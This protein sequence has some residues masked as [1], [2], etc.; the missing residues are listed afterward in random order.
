MEILIRQQLSDAEKEQNVDALK[1]TYQLIKS[2]HDGKSALDSLESFSFDLYV[3]CAE[4]A[5]QMGLPEISH[6]C[7]QMYFKGKAPVNQFLGRAY[8]CQSQLY[9]PVST[10][11]LEQFE[12]FNINLLKTIDFA[13]SDIRYYFLIYNASVIYWKNIRPFLKPGSRNFLIPSLSQIVSAL[14]HPDE[15]D[16]DWTAELMIELLECFLDASRVEEATTFSSTAATF[17]EENAPSRYKD[18]FSIMVRNKLVDAS[19]IE[20]K[21]ESC[22]SLNIIYKIQTIKGQLDKNQILEDAP[23]DLNNI[24]ELLKGSKKQVNRNERIS[25]LLELARLSLRLNCINIA[26][27]CLK[28][29][30]IYKIHDPGREIELD[31]LECDCEVQALGP[32]IETYAKSVVEAQLEVI[33]KLDLILNRAI[34]LR[35]PNIIQAVCTTQWNICL[36]LL[37]HNLQHH[38]RKPLLA[39]AEVLEKIDSMLILLRCQ[40]HMEI[41]RIEEKSDRVETAMEHLE[42]AINLDN[43]GQYHEYLKMAF[44]RLSL[45]TMLYKSLERLE[46]QASLMIEQ[47]KKGTANDSVRKKRSLLVNAGLA[48]APEAFQVVLDS[49]NEAKVPPSKHKDQISYLCA[50]AE[51]HAKNVEKADGHLKRLGHEN[52]KERIRLWSEIAKTA[53]KQSVW[54]VCRAACRFCLLYDDNQVIKVSKRKKLM[55]KKGSTSTTPDEP[56]VNVLR[57][58]PVPTKIF[59]LERDLLRTLAEVRCINAEATI[60][61]LRTEGVQLNDYPVLPIEPNTH[62]SGYSQHSTRSGRESDWNVY[63]NWI[64]RLSQYAMENFLRAVRIGEELNEAWI[65]HNTVVYVLNHNKHLIISK[66][67]R[68][69]VE[70]FQILFNAVKNVGNFGNSTVLVTLCNALARGLILPWIPRMV[71]KTDE[72]KLNEEGPTKRKKTALK[73]YDKSLTALITPVDPSGIHDIKAAVEVCEFAMR[74]PNGSAPDEPVPIALRQQVI[75]TWVKAKQLLQQQIGRLHGSEEESN[76]DGTSPMTKVFMGL[77][78]YSC[79]GLS[80]MDFLLP[81]LSQLVKMALECSWSDSLVQLQTLTRLMHFAHNLHDHELVITCSQKILELGKMPFNIDPKKKGINDYSARQEML[82]IASCTQGKSIMEN[83]AGKKHLRVTASNSFVESARYAGEAGNLNL[84]MVAARNFWNACLPFIGSSA[85]R[86]HLKAPTE[87]ILK[88]IIKA[89]EAKN[90]QEAS[91]MLHLHQW[92]T[93]DFQSISPSDGHFFPG[94]EEDLTLRTFLY[95]LL[96]QAYA[97][98]NE[99]E[100][101][102]KVLDEAVQILPRTKHRLPIFKHMVMVKAR[103]GR[104]YIMEIQKFRDETEVY[105]SDMWHRLASVSFDIVG[106]LSCYQNAIEV[107]Q[108]KESELKK[109]DNILGFAEWLYCKQ[110]PL[111]EAI[112]HLEWAIN[113]LLYLKPLQKSPDEE[114]VRNQ[115]SIG[116]LRSIKQLEAL[117]RAYTI[118]AVISGHRSTFYEQYCLMAYAFVIRMW[119]MSFTTAG[120]FLKAQTKVSPAQSAT[121]KSKDKKDGKKP[122]AT[123]VSPTS[124]PKKDKEKSPKDG[125]KGGSASKEKVKKKG[126]IDVLPG[127]VEEWASYECPDEMREAFKQDSSGCTVNRETILAPTRTLYYLDLLLKELQSM[128]CTHMTLPLLH[129]AEIIAHDVV[130]SKSLSNLYHLRLAKICLDLKMYQAASF[131]EKAVG[132]IFINEKEQGRFRQEIAFKNENAIQDNQMENKNFDWTELDIEQRKKL[133]TA[134]DKILELNAVTEKELN[135]LSLPYLWIEKAEVLIQLCLYQPARLLLSE[136]HQATQEMNNPCGVSR[137]L[138]LLAVLANLEKNHGQSKALLEKARLIGGNEQFWH[139]STFALTDAILGDDQEINEKM[140]QACHFLQK[141]INV[142][143]PLLKERPNR[144]SELGFIIACFEARK[145]YIQIDLVKYLI[146]TSIFSD[147]LATILLESYDKLIHIEKIFLSYGYKDRSADAL[148]ACANIH[149]ILGKH[150]EEAADK[151][152]HYIE[153]YR[154]AQCGVS[155]MEELFQHINNIL[156]VNET[157][158][159]NTPLMR[160]L[161]NMKVNFVEI[162]LD[163]FVLINIEKKNQEAR[164]DQIEQIIE[165]FVRFTPDSASGEQAWITLG[166]TV[167]HNAHAQLTSLPSLCGGCPDIRAKYL[168]LTGRSLH[169]LA[170]HIEPFN[171]DIQWCDNAIEVPKINSEKSPPPEAETIDEQNEV[172]S[173]M[174]QLTRKQLGDYRKKAN[175]LRKRQTWTHEYIFQSTEVLLQCINVAINNNLIDTLAAASLEMVECFGQFDPVSASQF[176]ALYQSCTASLIMKEILLGATLNSSSSQMAAMLH[177]Q[178]HLQQKGETSGLLKTIEHR[179]AAISKAWGSL[180]IS[181]HHFNIMNELPANFHIVILQ[182]SGDRSLLYGAV[183]EKVKSTNPKEQK[184]HQ[185]EKGGKEKGGQQKGKFAQPTFQAKIVRTSVN[186]ETFLNILEKVDVYKEEMMDSLL[187]EIEEDEFQRK[188]VSSAKLDTNIEDEDEPDLDFMFQAI[189]SDMEEYLKPVLSQLKLSELRRQSPSASPADSGKTRKGS[190]GKTKTDDSGK[191]KTKTSGQG[192][193]DIGECVILLADKD[194]LE[195]PLEALTIFQDD[196]ISSLSRDFSLQMVYNRIRK[197]EGDGE[198]KKS[199]RPKSEQRRGT[200]VPSLNRTLPP[201]CI[202]IDVHNVKY[203]V[204]PYND[205][206]EDELENPANSFRRILEK[207][208]PFTICWEGIMGDIHFPSYTEWEYILNNCSMLF[209]SAMARFLSHVALDKLVAM[210]IP[211]CQLIILSGRVHS[212]PSLIRLRN[213]DEGK[214]SLR[215]SLEKTT[216][217]AIILSL[218]GVRSV[219]L[220]QWFTTLEENTMRLESLCENFIKVGKTTGQAV[221]IL[222]RKKTVWDKPPE[223]SPDSLGVEKEDQSK[224]PSQPNQTPIHPSVIDA[225]LYG[226]PNTMFT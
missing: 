31:C 128:L 220:N 183:L 187:R 8:L 95:V 210:N 34:R 88:S 182:H 211:E 169:F 168:Y 28:E 97:D 78:M 44:H 3:L 138:Y 45:N 71:S 108:K 157:R 102:L 217:T 178:H 104:N 47:A 17:I 180:S 99:W 105:M 69:L 118:M 208:E 14:S 125:K 86:Q 61:L 131:H 96:F 77:E 13:L 142:L 145:A 198:G 110:F 200:K 134:K 137:S 107:L 51:H 225:I 216:E 175:E 65:V 32:K 54:D 33:Q 177:L 64:N 191:T 214:S 219:I 12:K 160:R 112:K 21:L 167:G 6:D 185:K 22:L 215:L 152:S 165:N 48:L 224:S 42:K 161:A 46:D 16:K 124:P 174:L 223:R 25:L 1:S 52:E 80:L 204:D 159:I 121:P 87:V 36:P 186:P 98:K 100:T 144:E 207:F 29:L 192:A 133:F 176:L 19:D 55:K 30:K 122:D 154:L 73:G 196:A 170:N 82:S 136:A 101:G 184:E 166:Q 9:T 40:V 4:Q 62:I 151:Q 11:S 132:D 94:A 18:L 201:N 15:E 206:R 194:L 147:E 202:S 135:G 162:I 50:K 89:S 111:S 120:L 140:M 109:V 103:L 172:P 163:I 193:E 53:R 90:K 60:Q 179:L 221:R 119:Q 212:K 117:F 226:L 83:L 143:R 188:Q 59:S 79:N 10:D 189:L 43:N 148:M 127:N 116:E 93:I 68:E 91:N 197:D 41:A 123:Q 155:Q 139:N 74:L 63:S 199:A 141:N 205:G 218:I 75:A 35:D 203:I 171:L 114:E 20:D 106:Q 129:L 81:N 57:E 153:A 85:D 126:P 26:V 37:Q 130:E 23:T 76:D 24:F 209:F 146:N 70:P 49:E 158:N 115:I 7:L 2:A 5:Y 213:Q 222:Q 58:S 66:R 195:L 149:R 39:I 156:P 38:I 164:A 150:T 92:P 190:P 84:A 173:S 72:K 181:S 67:Q 27:V 56:E 113:M